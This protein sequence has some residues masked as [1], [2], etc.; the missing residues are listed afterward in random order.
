M[1]F[2]KFSENLRRK[3]KN[4]KWPELC[5]QENRW[6]PHFLWN[7]FVCDIL[8]SFHLCGI[9]D[10]AEF[11]FVEAQ[12]FFILIHG[13]KAWVIYQILIWRWDGVVK[14]SAGIFTIIRR[15]TDKISALF[16]YV[17]ACH[18]PLTWVFLGG[19]LAASSTLCICLWLKLES[20][21]AFTSPESTSFSM[22]F[23]NI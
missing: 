2:F 9:E 6:M 15:W 5:E 11:P 12:N 22:A 14:S 8:I 16:P 3:S 18:E 10:M 4:S 23:K 20:P 1:N 19:I 17:H 21:N 7:R 13:C